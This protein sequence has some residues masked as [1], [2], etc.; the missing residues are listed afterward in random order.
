M[1]S[2]V[3]EKRGRRIYLDPMKLLGECYLYGILDLG[4]VQSHDV[5]KVARAMIGGGVDVIQLRAKA[6]DIAQVSRL[7]KEL[8]PLTSAAG[9]LLIVNDHPEVAK[10]VSIEG[11]HVGQDDVSVDKARAQAGGACIIGKSTHSFN[12]AIAAADEGADYIGFGP[13]Y[14]TPTKPT[15]GA[16]GLDDVAR[17]HEQLSLPIFCIGGIIIDNLRDVIVSGARRVVIVSGIL[18]A[19]DIAAYCR[20]AKALLRPQEKIQNP[21]PAI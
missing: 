1:T 12:Q 19:R 11:I 20:S 10:V 9:I 6:L 17:V 2:Q 15:Y 18:Q 16:I 13:L 21:N 4:Y 3:A 7:A 14:A 5:V 8:H